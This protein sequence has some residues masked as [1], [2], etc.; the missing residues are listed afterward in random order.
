MDTERAKSVGRRLLLGLGWASSIAAA[1]W[2]GGVVERAAPAR[3]PA[4][5]R[6]TTAPLPTA[7]DAAP[8]PAVPVL[9]PFGGSALAASELRQIIRAEL[10]ELRRD[11]C[12]AAAEPDAA[13]PA[14]PP[15]SREVLA[16]AEEAGGLVERA[17]RGGRWTG[18]DRR[19]FAEL[20]A[21][22]PPPAVFE[23]ERKLF[24]AIN[25]GAVEVSD[26]SAPFGHHGAE[27]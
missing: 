26:R 27:D 2:C 11:G 20:S 5:P 7:R 16:S 10:A 24:A 8:P 3:A 23:L 22:L 12:A 6:V 9:V 14:P 19:R 1:A 18:G 25:R 13:P 17:I 15:P 4:T 21:A